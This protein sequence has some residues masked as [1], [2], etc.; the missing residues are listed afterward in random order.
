MDIRQQVE[1]LAEQLNYRVVVR[2]GYL[3]CG[4]PTFRSGTEGIGSAIVRVRRYH[5]PDEATRITVMRRRC[6]S[7]RQA[8]RHIPFRHFPPLE[9]K[10]A[11]VGSGA[12]FIWPVTP[13]G[14]E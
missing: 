14:E 7:T 1:A 2:S 3:G 9:R 10:D 8:A 12:I 5:R 13:R 4:V 6:L 11:C